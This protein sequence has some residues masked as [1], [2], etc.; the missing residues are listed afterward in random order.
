V[1][2]A[3][4]HFSNKTDAFMQKIIGLAN[5]AHKKLDLAITQNSQSPSSPPQS[6]SPK[7]LSFLELQPTSPS[8]ALYNYET[9]S[10]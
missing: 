7:F 2:K 8:N 3:H 4:D 10:L 5:F 1:A 6:P 9:N